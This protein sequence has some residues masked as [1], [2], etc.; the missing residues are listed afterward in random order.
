MAPGGPPSRYG[1]SEEVGITP[2]RLEQLGIPSYELSESCRRIDPSLPPSSVAELHTDVR[3]IAAIFGVPERAEALIAHW[4]RR[5]AAVERRLPPEDERVSG[6]FTYLSGDDA[7]GTAPGLTIVPELN[8]LAG[9]TNV[10]ADLPEMWG[11]VSGEAV[12]DRDPDVIVAVDYGDSAVGASGEA[13]VRFLRDLPVLSEV[14]AVREGRFLVLPQKAVNPG[15]RYVDG[16]EQLAAV[17]YP[18][19]FSTT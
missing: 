16:I 14:S 11:P 19:R 6:V 9:G 18:D 7:P 15:I 10:F 8:R 12:V 2:E 13:K 3:N 17:L 5:V 4:D 1:F